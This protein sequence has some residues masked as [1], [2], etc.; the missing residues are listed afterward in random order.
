MNTVSRRLRNCLVLV[1][2]TAVATDMLNVA[3][4]TPN[5]MNMISSGRTFWHASIPC[6]PVEQGWRR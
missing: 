1:V 5:I 3:K 6:G 2:P 4:S